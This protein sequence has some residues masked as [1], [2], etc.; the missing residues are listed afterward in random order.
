M[1]ESNIFCPNCNKKI[2][3]IKKE[4]LDENGVKIEYEIINR[5]NYCR[6]FKDEEEIESLKRNKDKRD[7]F[8]KINHMT[9]KQFEEKHMNKLYYREKGLPNNIDKNYYLRDD[10]IIRNLSQISYRLLNYIL[11][12]HLFFA[13]IFT[14]N[15]RFDKYKPKD[16]SWG[17][18]IDKNFI[19]LKN[20]LSKKGIDSIEIFMNFIFKELFEKLY[21]KFSIGD[22][23]DLIDFEKD[24]E[25]LIQ[26]KIEKSIK[27]IKKYNEKLNKNNDD[28]NDPINL[29]KEK[30]DKSNYKK[31]E[32]PYYEYFY[33]SDC[34]DENLLNK[35]LKYT[36]NNKYPMINKYLD[37]NMNKK[38]E[39]DKYI[40]NKLSIF[41]K[42]LNLISEKYSHKITRENAKKKLL[43]DTEIYKNAE[44]AKL[45]DKFIEFYN[46]LKIYDNK[47][48][49]IKL[50]K[51]NKLCDFVIDDNNEVGKTYKDIYKIFIEKQNNEIKEILDIKI[52]EG[53]FNSNCRNRI[54]V[55]QIKEDEIFTLNSSEQFSF[56]DIIYN[57]SYRKIID[58]QD[59]KNYN[60]FELNL[61]DIEED[62]TEL[63]LKN[64][65]LL[66]TDLIIDFIYNNEIFDN[67]VNDLIITF[68]NN[69]NCIDTSLDDKKYLYNCVKKNKENL[70]IYE[71]IINNFIILIEY[72]N[73]IK[74]EENNDIG[75]E[76]KISQ[77]LKD[78]DDRITFDFKKI[79]EERKEL[80]LN[81]TS[82]IFDYYLKLIFG[83]IKKKL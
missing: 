33:Y 38:K 14:K 37:Y 2:G 26:E 79:F 28:K 48:N 29:L 67:Q 71:D 21:E 56:I 18:I 73:I 36:D 81:K 62:M 1:Q 16:M 76:T 44:L 61:I 42:V 4:I 9:L 3:I 82:D 55:Q 77:V 47:G 15:D 32:Y 24:L 51:E 63:L 49:K 46:E 59:E 23:K 30:Y 69:Y 27:E 40:L 54:N 65:K 19:L 68:K 74:K 41:N 52:N 22:Y 60:S 53:I 13:R 12:S 7:I 57:S 50:T 20:E 72:L 64:K 31:E 11:Y 78:I 6:I 39:D 75:S 8:C 35:I 83:D 5:G 45:I 17:E 25:K 10:K 80:T 66:N 70:E 34:L 43:K 58:T